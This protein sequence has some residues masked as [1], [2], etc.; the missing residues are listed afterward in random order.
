VTGPAAR[1]A[2]ADPAREAS[3]R[4]RRAWLA[5]AACAGA[6]F[7]FSG[8]DFSAANTSRILGPLLRWLF[9]DLAPDAMAT[10][11]MAVRK[12]AH[13]TEYGLLGLLAFRAL[14]LSLAISNARAALLGLGLV[15]LVSATDELR[16]SFIASRTGTIRDVCIDLVGGALGVGL[17]V[18]LHRAAGVGPPPAPAPGPRA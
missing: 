13:L 10:L 6:I 17:L 1:A 14:R 12:A 2:R 18:L 15:L 9:P 5:V 3:V 11:H 8:D 7:V 16:Q 4:A